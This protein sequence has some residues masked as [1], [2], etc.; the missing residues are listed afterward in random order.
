VGAYTAHGPEGDLALAPTSHDHGLNPEKVGKDPEAGHANSHSGD[1]KQ[2]L[3]LTDENAMAQMIGV[4]ILEFGV[5]LH[6]H[7]PVFPC[8][9]MSAFYVA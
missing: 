7:V 6:R 1:S 3:L 9:H 5:I 8:F 4:A 2:A